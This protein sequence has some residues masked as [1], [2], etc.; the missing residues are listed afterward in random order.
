MD[1]LAQNTFYVHGSA[2]NSYRGVYMSACQNN[3]LDGNT[4]VVPVSVAGLNANAYGLYMQNSTGYAIEDNNFTSEEIRP[5]GIGVYI[6]NSGTDANEIYRNEFSNLQYSIIAQDINRYGNIRGLVIKCNDFS[7]TKSDITVTGPTLISANYGIA[8]HQGASSSD[9]T[10]MAGNLFYYNT[11]SID[12]DDL[13]NGLNHFNYFY[14]LNSSSS[15]VNP[16]DITNNTVTKYGVSFAPPWSYTNGCP[17]HET[18]GGTLL[19]K[20]A[21]ADEK[22]DSTASILAVL[23][24]NGDTPELAGEVDQSTPAQTVDL[25][26]ELM[27]TSPYLSDSVVESAIVKEDVLPNAL[28]R[29]IMVANAHS[30]KSEVLMNTL[31]T[32][33]DPMPDYMKEQILKGRS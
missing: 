14:P 12:F 25:Y 21:I 2:F 23:V 16:Q 20:M 7:N 8:Y 33:W 22:A 30:S 27:A 24:D 26:N 17:P 31:D 32:R 4:F 9:P 11:A 28:L 3:Q 5:T 13:N 15:N 18:G 19:T 10:Q 29:D 1:V 6:N